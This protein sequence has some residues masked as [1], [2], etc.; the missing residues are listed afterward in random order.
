VISA[1]EPPGGRASGIT[2]V[3]TLESRLESPL[4][5]DKAVISRLMQLVGLP[6]AAVGPIHSGDD[7]NTIRFRVR[8]GWR[9]PRSRH[10]TRHQGTPPVDEGGTVTRSGKALLSSD[11]A[12]MVKRIVTEV[13]GIVDR[14]EPARDA[15]TRKVLTE[16]AGWSKRRRGRDCISR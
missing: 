11:E 16:S 3:I 1:A 14:R 7:R 13:V 6:S 8:S 5:R 9:D 2:L 12:A 10:G 15:A 4:R